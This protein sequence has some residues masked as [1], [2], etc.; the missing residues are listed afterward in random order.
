MDTVW[1]I[2]GA[3]MMIVIGSIFWI[4]PSPRDRQRMVLRQCAFSQGFQVKQIKPEEVAK[5]FGINEPESYLYYYYKMGRYQ[6]FQQL[7]PNHLRLIA[8]P[9]GNQWLLSTGSKSA[10]EPV[11]QKHDINLDNLQSAVKAILMSKKEVGLLWNEKAD[12]KKLEEVLLE[13]KIMFS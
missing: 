4:L 1:L 13:L 6:Q 5:K 2:A 3:S 7:Y 10:E 8:F 11:E 12:I 9:D